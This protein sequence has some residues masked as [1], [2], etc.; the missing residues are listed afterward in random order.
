M[1][2]SIA[3][4]LDEAIELARYDP[5]ARNIRIERRYVS[6]LLLITGVREH[7]TQAFLNIIYNA[8]DAMPEGGDLRISLRAEGDFIVIQ[9]TDT[10]TGIAPDQMGQVFE[11]F[12]TTKGPG[13]GT[14]LGL[15]VTKHL[16]TQ[17][18]GRIALESRPG[19]E[20]HVRIELPLLNS[21]PSRKKKRE[22]ADRAPR[23]LRER[24]A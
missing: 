1:A 2:L 15:A 24:G 13:R 11:P 21:R 6:E 20:T 14:G 12:F 3:S 4:T 16:I 8:M 22:A 5:R 17:H 19:V 10:G 23:R 7:L 18:N 9:F